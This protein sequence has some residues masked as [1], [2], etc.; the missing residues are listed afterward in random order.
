MREAFHVGGWE[1]YEK[2]FSSGP[3][4]LRKIVKLSLKWL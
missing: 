1:G 3:L 4:D 2:H